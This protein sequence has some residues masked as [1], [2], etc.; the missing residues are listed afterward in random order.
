MARRRLGVVL[1]IPAPLSDAVDGLRRAFG[2][3][4]LGRVSPHITLVPPVNVADRDLPDALAGLRAAAARARPLELDLG[5]VAVFPGD[6]H[7]AY[8]GVSGDADAL[9]GLS[10]LRADALRPPLEREIDHDFVPHVTLTQGVDPARLAA[11]GAASVGWTAEPVR[12]ERLHLLEEQHRPGGRRWIPIA[13]VP[14]EP[15][16]VVG[17]GGLEVTLTPSELVDPE[18]AAVLAEAGAVAGSAAP[19]D[20]GDQDDEHDVAPR[21]GRALVVTA[22]REGAVVGLARG[23]T[24]GDDGLLV[25]RWV[26]GADADLARQLEATWHSVAADRGGFRPWRA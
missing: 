24:V 18:A 21:D 23:W 26:S 14:L 3:P 6:E 4:A 1:L 19:G 7:V 10:R 2:D 25:D 17:R 13:D 9:A 20:R 5:P 15:A 16:R 12:L 8:L 11:V 22:R